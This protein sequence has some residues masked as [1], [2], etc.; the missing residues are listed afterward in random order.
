MTRYAEQ[1]SVPSEKSL[2]EIEEDIDKRFTSGNKIPVSQARITREEWHVLRHYIRNST[3][4][5]QP[6]DA[7]RSGGAE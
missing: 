4:A 7:E 3:P 5:P 6:E 1:T 2:S